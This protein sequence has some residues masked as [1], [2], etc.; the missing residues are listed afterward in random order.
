MEQNARLGF[1]RV[2]RL[3]FHRVSRTQV[4]R[5]QLAFRVSLGFQT[6]VSSGFQNASAREQ[7]AFRVSSGF[8]NGFNRARG[9]QMETRVINFVYERIGLIIVVN[10][11][12]FT[13]PILQGSYK[14]RALENFVFLKAIF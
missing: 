5:E 6:R 12:N 1:H 9:F 7:L 13:R 3:G 4:A 11:L 14:S 8:Q 10:H 2:S